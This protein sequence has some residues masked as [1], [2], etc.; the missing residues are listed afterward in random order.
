MSIQKQ[1]TGMDRINPVTA[2]KGLKTILGKNNDALPV[3]PRYV[4]MTAVSAPTFSGNRYEA[5]LFGRIYFHVD[6]NGERDSDRWAILLHPNFLNGRIMAEKIGPI[7]Y[8]NGFNILAPDMRSFGKSQGKVA[9]GFLE[10]FDTYD[11][12]LRLNAK[13]HPS[14]IV[15]HGLS[16]GGATVN[17]LSGIEGFVKGGSIGNAS[18]KS[19]SQ[20]HVKG[21]VTDGGYTNIADFGDYRK[22]AKRTGIPQEDFTYYADASNS[23]CHNQIPMLVIQG[24]RDTL[25][26]P[27]NALRIAGTSKGNVTL[28][29]D[30]DEWHI[31]ILLGKRQSEYR[32][33]VCAF[34]NEI[35]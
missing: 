13:F 29:N 10:M 1:I 18:V 14:A 33:K 6:E 34:L 24:S 16:L 25:V 7:Y 17:F 28:W 11:W 21:L 30:I 32:E 4:R 35:E 22:L 31:F 9:L 26:N 27:D 19:L 2:V 15:I 20:L 12:L 5:K 8:E 23:L 3:E